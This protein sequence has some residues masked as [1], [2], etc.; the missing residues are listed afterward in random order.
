MT[1]HSPSKKYPTIFFLAV[2]N[3]KRVEKLG[4][5][6]EKDFMC[7]L[8]FCSVSQHP[9]MHLSLPDSKVV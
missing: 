7:M 9:R 8:D 6:E 1:V 2:S 3:S 4:I 5:A